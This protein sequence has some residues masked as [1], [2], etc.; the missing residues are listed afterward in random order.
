MQIGRSYTPECLSRTVLAASALA[1]TLACGPGEP[2]TVVDNG[3]LR[4]EVRLEPAAPR[5]GE[6]RMELRLLGPD[7][8]P[9]RDARVDVKVAMAAMG[10]M[11]AMGGPAEVRPLP[12][13]RYAASYA[14]DMDGSWRVDIRARDAEGRTLVAEGSLLTGQPGLRLS[15]RALERP[16]ADGAPTAAEP[17]AGDVLVES[18]RRQKIG[19]RIAPVRR[20]DFAVTVRT[21]GLV[22]QDAG[23]VI[24]V[25]PRVGGTVTR[26]GVSA[27]GESVRGGDLL[28][29]LE[30]PDLL[31]AQ[32]EYLAAL[33]AWREAVAVLRA[34]SETAP[35]SD[36][37][38]EAVVRA[39]ESRLA[40]Y[41]M[42]AADVRRLRETGAVETA[43]AFRAPAS[44]V[45]VEKNVVAGSTTTPGTTL[46]RIGSLARVWIE[47]ELYEADLALVAPGVA[48]EITLPYLPGERFAGSVSLIA[49][50]IDA[51]TRTARARIELPNPGAALLPGMYA[52]VELRREL[53][54]RLVVP[55]AAVLYTGERRVVFVD[56]GDGRLRPRTI[57][58]GRR[59]GDRLE[60]VAGL[61]EGE[62]IVVSGNYLVA[63]ESRLGA[64]EA[65]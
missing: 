54:E 49:P 25:A 39:A 50:A 2:A 36:D 11:P 64:P 59:D 45:V 27:A 17:E 3:G 7:G 53:G 30:S 18:D 32:R 15:A 62:R 23:A 12:D 35:D 47:A 24:D 42:A 65:W 44:G 4:L 41:G 20:E 52:R 28:F 34:A 57:R 55:A 13:G 10:A 46:F 31:L 19:V 37:R 40:L 1:L 56:L 22:V 9:V 5:S 8:A 48:A 29:S 14:L 51:A 33:R 58:T 21:V 61:S 6:N 60:V 43:V 26:V 38:G 16:A 63:S